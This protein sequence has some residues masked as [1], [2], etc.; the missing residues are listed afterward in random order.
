M[1]GRFKLLLVVL[2]IGLQ[3]SH[4][5]WFSD[6]TEEAGDFFKDK[7]EKAKDVVVDVADSIN[8]SGSSTCPELGGHFVKF[9]TD[10]D[11]DPAPEYKS[12][13]QEGEECVIV[14]VNNFTMFMEGYNDRFRNHD[15]MNIRSY[16]NKDGGW[17][18]GPQMKGDIKH[19]RL[20]PPYRTMAQH[21]VV[22]FGEY[23]YVCQIFTDHIEFYGMEE[24]MV[25]RKNGEYS[26]RIHITFE[27]KLTPEE[28]KGTFVYN[29]YI[30]IG[31]DR[32]FDIKEMLRD[33]VLDSVKI[34]GED[35]PGRATKR[36]NEEKT[37]NGIDAGK[38]SGD[39][40]KG[41]EEYCFNRGEGKS[42]TIDVMGGYITPVDYTGVIFTIKNLVVQARW[43]KQYCDYLPEYFIRHVHFK[44]NTVLQFGKVALLETHKKILKWTKQ[45]GLLSKDY[46]F[47][48]NM[49]M[50]V[51]QPDDPIH[52]FAN[53][54]TT[55]LPGATTL[56]FENFT[57]KPIRAITRN[58]NY[59]DNE[60]V[61]Y[62]IEEE[63][64]T[65]MD[66]DYVLYDLTEDPLDAAYGLMVPLASIWLGFMLLWG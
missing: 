65:T 46:I 28:V 58:P 23:K 15:Y 5:N 45:D 50:P 48:R 43:V 3:T 61:E 30:F 52:T 38:I 63:E 31:K 47:R 6:L 8:P 62:A 21:P 26:W 41:I 54:F 18:L 33:E 29:G 12:P 56:N 35:R 19:R 25:V 1:S 66:P 2:F 32:V 59:T 9:I 37:F 40:V 36:F 16:K 51:V 60:I 10:R 22:I 20:D 39:L 64:S 57:M 55:T 14:D 34:K 49:L 42:C 7:Y 11:P 53:K 17:D 44:Q 13:C 27:K 4:G 24:P